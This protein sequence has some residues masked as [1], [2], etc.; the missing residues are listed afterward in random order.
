MRKV[1]RCEGYQNAYD[2][3][4]IFF[5]FLLQ[6]GIT[7]L[8]LQNMFLVTK[9]GIHLKKKLKS[10]KTLTN[11]IC[12]GHISFSSYYAI[13]IISIFLSDTSKEN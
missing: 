5:I 12:L 1:K 10:Q 2:K 7:N 6:S 13:T 4:P 9:K 11:K 8:F 3:Q